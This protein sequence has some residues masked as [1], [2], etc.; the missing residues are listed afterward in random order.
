MSKV[1]FV[2]PGQGSQFV[3]MGKDL[4]D[5]Y[6]E[7]RE[8][9]DASDS[10]L[11]IPISGICF[12][13]PEEDLKQTVNTQPALFITSVACCRILAAKGVRPDV[14]AGHSIGEY[15]ALVAAGAV[16]FEDALPLVRRRGELMYK[17]GIERPGAMAAIIGLSAAKALEA[18][19]S[20]SDRGIVEI[21]NYNSSAQIVISGEL[22]AV[23]A[24]S[25]FA[26]EAGARK[27]MPL[28]V[29][30]AFHSRLM[31]PASDALAIELART[32]FADA[33]LPIIANISADYEC[34]ADDIREALA[35]QISGSVRWEET[36]QRMA[37]DGVYRYVEV[38]PG[39]AL[40]GLLKRAVESAKLFNA[41]DAPG[42]ER[43]IES[44]GARG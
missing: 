20:A 29:S 6:A 19:K 1:A 8:V 28:S 13:G 22:D 11:G 37:S 38:G 41:G 26:K 30:G 36:M 5:R 2:F 14:A 25:S 33:D 23:E 10:I 9:Y 18:C 24:A 40:T 32:P 42:I 27:V 4:Y 21:A 12:E 39:K 43:T 7:A 35:K 34:R 44:I 3:G 15:A 17:A 16:R 31:Q